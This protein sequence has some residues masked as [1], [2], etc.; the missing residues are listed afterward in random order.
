M[1]MPVVPVSWG[2]LLDKISI[3]DI[4][5]ERISAP[6][7]LDN[8]RRERTA[9][10][11]FAEPVLAGRADVAAVMAELRDV[12]ERLWTIED[13]IRAHERA[14]DFG[15][16]FIALARAVYRTNDER[17]RLK[18]RINILLGSEFVEEKHYVD[19]GS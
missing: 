17:G 8:V 6:A 19:Y 16:R 12:N 13:D 4:K 1:D 2:E 10:R 15:P 18:Q 5:A 14:G 11:A 7:K 9:L 3:L